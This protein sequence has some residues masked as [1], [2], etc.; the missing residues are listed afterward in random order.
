VQPTL[1]RFSESSLVYLTHL[2]TD[3]LAEVGRLRIIAWEACGP[4]PKMAPKVGDMWIDSHDEHAHHWVVSEEGRIVAAA[5]MCVHTSFCELPDYEDLAD[6]ESKFLRPVASI[7]RLVVHP[8][9]CGNGLPN[10]FDSARL[11]LALELGAKSVIG[12]THLKARIKSLG[13]LGFKVIGEA[14]QRSVPQAPTIVL[15]TAIA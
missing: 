15:M 1:R 2:D 12:C 9:C 5:R 7:N 8:E 6:C 10:L 13:E 14:P 4:R 11:R 3:T